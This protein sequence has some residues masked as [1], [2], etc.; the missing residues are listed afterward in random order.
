MSSGVKRESKFHVGVPGTSRG[1]GLN[2]PPSHKVTAIDDTAIIAEYCALKNN[3]SQ[4]CETRRVIP[5][6]GK[7]QK[8][9]GSFSVFLQ[10]RIFQKRSGRAGKNLKTSHRPR[11][12]R[13]CTMPIML[14]VP[15]PSPFRLLIMMAETTAVPH[16]YSAPYYLPRLIGVRPLNGASGFPDLLPPSHAFRAR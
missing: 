4:S 9:R 10:W 1:N 14:R 12:S 11:A 2:H 7:A 15:W 3:T 16:C 6:S 13:A 5:P 8:A